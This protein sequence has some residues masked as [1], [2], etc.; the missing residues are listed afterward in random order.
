MCFIELGMLGF[1]SIASNFN[2]NFDLEDPF[3]PLFLNMNM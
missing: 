3:A 1:E 2:F